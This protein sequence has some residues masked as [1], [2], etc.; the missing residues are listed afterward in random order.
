MKSNGGMWWPS[1]PDKGQ[2]EVETLALSA[3]CRF[4]LSKAPSYCMVKA[5]SA[6]MAHMRN[7]WNMCTVN[8]CLYLIEMSSCRF[9]AI[10][11]TM[12]DEEIKLQN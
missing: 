7:S 1:P 6:V 5:D 4:I 3:A 11:K 10:S 9:L 12:P 8:I 2:T